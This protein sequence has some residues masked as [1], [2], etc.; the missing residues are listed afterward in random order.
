[1]ATAISIKHRAR[2]SRQEAELDRRA[3]AEHDARVASGLAFAPAA[4]AAAEAAHQAAVARA[5]AEAWPEGPREG[6]RRAHGDLLSARSELTQ[7]RKHAAVATA[8]RIEREAEVGRA[9][10]AVDALRRSQTERLRDQLAGLTTTVIKGDEAAEAAA[11]AAS[12]KARR[13]L[14]VVQ[15]A[16]EEI[17][18]GVS[19]AEADVRACKAAVERA[20]LAVIEATRIT[21]QT[22]LRDAEQEIDGL[23]SVLSGLYVD[24]RYPAIH[25]PARLKVLLEDA[26]GEIVPNEAT[27]MDEKTE[28]W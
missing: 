3:R 15:A 25:W 2:G 13:T 9:K 24:T 8:Y 27:P 23:R 21:W 14:A 17:A 19:Q 18:A 22:R 5:F 1:L 11:M 12:E 20:A 10:E 28:I 6:L 16:E 26:E 4:M 7:R